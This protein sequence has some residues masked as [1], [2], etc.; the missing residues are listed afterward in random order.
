MTLAPPR[1]EP[2]P[3]SPVPGPRLPPR[4]VRQLQTTAP[5]T[6]GARVLVVSADGKEAALPAI[7]QALDYL[8][9]PYHLHLAVGN[10]I[11]ITRAF[12]SD[13]T[14]GR[15]QG[16]ILAQGQTSYSPD[17]GQSY[18]SALSEEEWQALWDYAAAYGVRQLGWYTY[19]TLDFGWTVPTAI[20]T[21]NRPYPVEYTRA[22]RELFS[23]VA[24]RAPLTLT[25]AYT[26][27]APLASPLPGE[28]Q[29]ATP[30]ITDTAGNVLA[31]LTTYLDGREVLNLSFDSNAVLTHTLTLAYGLVRWVTRGLFLGERH[32]TLSA[33]VDDYLIANALWE[34]QPSGQ[35]KRYRVT[36][37]DMAAVLA[38]Q[39]RQAASSLTPGFKLDLVFNGIGASD[40][41]DPLVR[42]TSANG[43][44]FKW[45][46]HT[47]SHNL[48]DGMPAAVVAAEVRRNSQ[49]A[50]ELG[51]VGFSP[52]NL[53][54]P[55]ITGLRD[56]TA[57]AF[58]FLQGV[59]YLVS[60]A[61]FAD[62]LPDRPNTGLENFVQPD[63]F[64]IPRRAN[65]LFYNVT[66]PDEWVSEYNAYYRGFFGRDSSYAEILE[67]ESDVLLNYLLKGELYPWMFHQSN[68][69]AYDGSR[70]LLTDLLD[71]TL[72]K[73]AG[74]LSLPVL[75]PPME[76]L[77]LRA[78]R[79]T[80]AARGGVSATIVAGQ[81]ITLTASREATVPLTGVPGGTV[82]GGD[83][84]RWVTVRPGSPVT[85]SLT[86]P[87]ALPTQHETQFLPLA[88]LRG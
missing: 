15:Y 12:L 5:P 37:E 30:L 63:L 45:I 57:M 39:Q 64:M 14:V 27:L 85:L 80:S 49:V 16:I 32:L 48:L 79:R 61:S 18:R 8:G 65:N 76:E 13:G 20:D 35:A 74:L 69:R 4:Q 9:T 87:A 36:A 47:Y 71:R 23:Y 59:R 7:T 58:A 72:A 40:R 21:T 1:L 82:Y 52:L 26:F 55:G 31:L 25:G 28:I 56:R 33:Q 50:S 83:S 6:Y 42:W 22:G 88:W 62:Q 2:P 86:T 81:Q 60:D 84:V 43:A 29:T 3:S 19:P 67:R 10:P 77:G 41:T 46:N 54:T 11:T 44:S 68:L 78:A 73:Y 53:V 38:W 34:P 75:S 51:L 24:A 66:T 70:T 17:G